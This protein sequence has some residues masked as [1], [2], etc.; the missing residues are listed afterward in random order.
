LGASGPFEHRTAPRPTGEGPQSKTR[1][2]TAKAV[3]QKL[4]AKAVNQKLG[5][6]AVNQKL[7]AK[8]VK[9]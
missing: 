6:K 2:P 5:A 4:G 8:A 1:A 3:N 7:G 9:P